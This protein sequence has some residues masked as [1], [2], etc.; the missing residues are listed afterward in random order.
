VSRRRPDDGDEE[1]DDEEA[2]FFGAAAAFFFQGEERLAAMRKA[3]QCSDP[4]LR[5]AAQAHLIEEHI[6]AGARLSEEI[7]A[8][9]DAGEI[10]LSDEGRQAALETIEM[11]V[12]RP[13][14]YEPGTR[15]VLPDEDDQP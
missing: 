10:E 4:Y 7:L 1:F 13:D 15:V 2:A 6:Q 9:A 12:D 11:A 5:E 14:W 8:A 3:K